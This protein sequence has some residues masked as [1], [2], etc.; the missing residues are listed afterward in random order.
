MK[1][2]DER[3]SGRINRLLASRFP[4]RTR[5]TGKCQVVD[6]RQAAGG[7]R[8]DVINMEGGFL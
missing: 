7:L 5:H 3:S 2:G 6:R 4:Q 1:Q 8:R